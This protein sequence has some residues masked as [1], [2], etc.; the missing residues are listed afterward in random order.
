MLQFRTNQIKSYCRVVKVVE[1]VAALST[2]LLFT[3]II[4]VLNLNDVCS[5]LNKKSMNKNIH[6][7]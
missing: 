2:D 4:P 7:H 5:L 6:K 3:T 1:A